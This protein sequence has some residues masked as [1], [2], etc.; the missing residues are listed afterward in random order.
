MRTVPT[1]CPRLPLGGAMR[2]AGD[3][4][5]WGAAPA[6]PLAWRG[7]PDAAW[8]DVDAVVAV[9]RRPG[10]EFFAGVQSEL[11]HEHFTLFANGFGAGMS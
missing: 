6:T 3:A 1:G 11:E 8:L 4:F 10:N 5:S 7:L 2:R 9:F